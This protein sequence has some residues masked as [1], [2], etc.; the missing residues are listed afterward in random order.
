LFGSKTKDDKD[1]FAAKAAA[2]GSVVLTTTGKGVKVSVESRMG[3]KLL[4]TEP[5]EGVT[6][7]RFAVE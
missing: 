2:D 5:K 3:I 4:E 6:T 1:F 7:G